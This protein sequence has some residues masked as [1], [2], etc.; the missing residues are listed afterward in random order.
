M[1][2][3]L[4]GSAKGLA[5]DIAARMLADR[6]TFAVDAGGDIRIGGTA[7]VPRTVHIAHPLDDDAHRFTVQPAPSPPAACAPASGRPP[8]ATPT[9]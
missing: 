5:V 1:R 8:R 9:T 4:G 3:D 6:P 7:R 2:L